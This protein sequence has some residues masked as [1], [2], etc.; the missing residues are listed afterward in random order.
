MYKAEKDSKIYAL[1]Q[2]N[3]DKLIYENQLKYAITEL[4]ILKKCTNKC[5]FII[6]LY[7]AFQTEDYLYIALKYLPF[8]TLKSIIEK[9]GKLTPKEATNI[10]S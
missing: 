1:K 7:Y 4:N 10:I 9:R 6:P 2:I 3:K 5:A 8:G